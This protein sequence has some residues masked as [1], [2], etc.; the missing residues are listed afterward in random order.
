MHRWRPIRHLA[1]SGGLA[2]GGDLVQG[3]GQAADVSGGDAS[4]R[5]AAVASHEDVVILSQTVHLH[6]R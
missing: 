1:Y 4:H 6:G 2:V 5:D 3:L